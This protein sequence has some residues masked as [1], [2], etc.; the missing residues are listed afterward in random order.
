MKRYVFPILFFFG[1]L[2]LVFYF[3]F[4]S[5]L[6]LTL[7]IQ[8][9]AKPYLGSY[10]FSQL[11]IGR[12]NFQY[13]ATLILEDVSFSL[14]HQEDSLHFQAPR[15][16]FFDVPQFYKER[17][18]LKIFFEGLEVAAR[19]FKIHSLDIK[20]L[21]NLQNR[22]VS[23]MDGVFYIGGME[24]GPYRMTDITARVKKG[25]QE[26]QIYEIKSLSYGGTLQGQL[27]I[28]HKPH[29]T[30]ILWLEFSDLNPGDLKSIN[31]NLF[32]HLEGSLR[33]SFRI[34]GQNKTVDLLAIH[35]SLMN[36]GIIHADLMQG[37]I[38]QIKHQEKRKQLESLLKS[39]GHCPVE[40]ASVQISNSGEYKI[41]LNTNL[42]NKKFHLNIQE[43]I[44]IPIVNGLKE[45]LLAGG[46]VQ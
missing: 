32:P 16:T 23:G 13:P 38:P 45:F 7:A 9:F 30:Y 8:H 46:K 35:L 36:G 15:F 11:K 20:A 2:F 12:Q 42:K 44:D 43:T 18:H 19:N 37:L 27:Q 17:Q 41:S 14:D 4:H 31:E 34:V 29:L 22:M 24:L 40:E 21:I 5:S 25:F 26:L 28:E 1:I 39:E 3:L 33:G 10:Q 6:F